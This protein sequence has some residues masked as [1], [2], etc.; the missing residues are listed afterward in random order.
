MPFSVS[1]FAGFKNTYMSNPYIKKKC[2]IPFVPLASRG[3]GPGGVKAL[4]ECPPMNASLYLTFS[5]R[6]KES[7]ILVNY[8][9]CRT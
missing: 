9:F 2:I 5:L 6:K 1:E 4:A 7:N 3:G 8:D